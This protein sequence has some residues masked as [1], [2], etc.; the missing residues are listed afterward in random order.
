MME[1]NKIK[2]MYWSR[3]PGRFIN[4]QTGEELTNKTFSGNVREWYETLISCI[5]EAS[6]LIHKRNLIPATH[7]VASP[8][9]CTIL[10]HTTDYRMNYSIDEYGQTR[11]GDEN[12]DRFIQQFEPREIGRL[13]NKFNVVLDPIVP[14]NELRIELRTKYKF[15]VSKTPEQE[16]PQISIEE[17]YPE[18]KTVD[19]ITIKIFDMNVL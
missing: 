10:E 2:V 18:T 13:S 12:V 9:V 7:V 15:S 11:F 4:Q 5:N 17:T 3:A 6:V 14:V 8:D 19:S 1:N 16:R